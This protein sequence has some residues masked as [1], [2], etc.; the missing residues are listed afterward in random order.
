MAGRR[1]WSKAESKANFR[2]WLEL[3]HGFAQQQVETLRVLLLVRPADPRA[4]ATVARLA[5]E[6]EGHLDK[7]ERQLFPWLR[8]TLPDGAAQVQALVDDHARLLVAMEDARAAP[9]ALRAAAVEQLARLLERHFGDEHR[10]ATAA[11]TREEDAL[12]W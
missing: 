5:A 1:R 9:E 12:D 8:D 3:E 10:L 11:F 2:G 6:L 4:A 7:E